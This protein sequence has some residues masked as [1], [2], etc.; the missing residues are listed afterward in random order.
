[1]Y[2]KSVFPRLCAGE[3]HHP[4]RLGD[5]QHHTYPQLGRGRILQRGPRALQALHVCGRD[6]VQGA[7]EI[8]QHGLPDLRQPLWE[9]SLGHLT[10]SSPVS[11]QQSCTDVEITHFNMYSI[12][13]TEGVNGILIVSTTHVA[14]NGI[15]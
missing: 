15:S 4:Q 7:G 13:K 12:L 2:Y 5:V 1:M 10:G 8:P 3:Q 11:C 14:P 9:S 6:A